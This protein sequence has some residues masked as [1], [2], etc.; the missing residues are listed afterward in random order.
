MS[1]IQVEWACDWPLRGIMEQ[2]I[3]RKS[4]KQAQA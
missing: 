3:G 2:G 1:L 4:K